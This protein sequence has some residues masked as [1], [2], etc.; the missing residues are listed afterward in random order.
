MQADLES[1]VFPI[2]VVRQLVGLTERQIR[3][4]DKM[5]LVTPY[6]TKGG[7]RMYSEKDIALLR[8]VKEMMQRGFRVKEVKETLEQE[9]IAA[10][11]RLRPA[12]GSRTRAGSLAT[13]LEGDDERPVVLRSLYPVSDQAVLMKTLDKIRND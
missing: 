5:G 10:E 1:P 3:Y 13:S 12:G 8:R 6:R 2:G 4:Y 7:T 11:R 9:R